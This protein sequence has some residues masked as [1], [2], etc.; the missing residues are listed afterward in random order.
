MTPAVGTAAG[1]DAIRPA[2]VQLTRDGE[3]VALRETEGDLGSTPAELK[4]DVIPGTYFA[5]VEDPKTDT[6]G[7]SERHPRRNLARARFLN[8]I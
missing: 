7:A 8:R 5:T 6:T 1:G 4:I 3:P 2:R